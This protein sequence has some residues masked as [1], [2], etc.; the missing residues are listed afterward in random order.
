[1]LFLS[2]SF[3]E[4][5]KCIPQKMIKSIHRPFAPRWCP[6]TFHF[7]DVLLVLKRHTRWDQAQGEFGEELVCFGVSLENVAVAAHRPP[8][9]RQVLCCFKREQVLVTAIFINFRLKT[10]VTN[11][12]CHIFP[13]S[14]CFFVSVWTLTSNLHHRTRQRKST[15]ERFCTLQIVDTVTYWWYVKSIYSDWL[16]QT[17]NGAQSPVREEL[18]YLDCI[19]RVPRC[20]IFKI[21]DTVTYMIFPTVKSMWWLNPHSHTV[22]YISAGLMQHIVSD[23]T[24]RRI[25][26]HHFFF[27]FSIRILSRTLFAICPAWN[28]SYS[29]NFGFGVQL[30]ALGLHNISMTII[31]WC[32][33]FF[34]LK[35]KTKKKL[36]LRSFH[37]GNISRHSQI[38][39]EKKGGKGKEKDVAGGGGIKAIYSND[40]NFTS[41]SVSVGPLGALVAAERNV[42]AFSLQKRCWR[43]RKIAGA[44]GEVC[45]STISPPLKDASAK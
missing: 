23:L 18:Y 44:S 1:M 3:G 10:P 6:N 36:F 9:C 14:V 11:Y 19:L 2:P 12:R 37:S 43:S 33:K 20:Q 45:K 26:S 30:Q 4:N 38:M 35:N 17:T 24:S 25:G 40:W 27:L 5:G 28:L 15:I 34:F 41:N 7:L 42:S 39:K 16:F 8:I 22:S 32:Q 13:F 31:L 29:S 21:T